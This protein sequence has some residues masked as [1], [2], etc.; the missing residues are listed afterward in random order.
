MPCSPEAPSPPYHPHTD[1]NIGH[2]PHYKSRRFGSRSAQDG[3][4]NGN[5]R[6]D[7]RETDHVLQRM[8]SSWLPL[9]DGLLP[10]LGRSTHTPDLPLGWGGVGGSSG[11][12]PVKQL[13]FL[14]FNTFCV[15]SLKCH[16]VWANK[17]PLVM[18]LREF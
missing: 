1:L 11:E 13:C 14:S 7:V 5:L 4:I 2:R 16:A 10:G 17:C 6:R 3:I 12:R 15:S 18:C 9:G 8:G